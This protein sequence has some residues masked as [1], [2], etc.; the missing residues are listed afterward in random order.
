MCGIAGMLCRAGAPPAIAATPS[1][2]DGM[3]LTG[4]VSTQLL[5]RQLIRAPLDRPDAI[6]LA[7]VIDHVSPTPTARDPRDPHD[8]PS[9]LPAAQLPR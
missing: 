8:A 6:E 5:H 2:A 1:S 7:M 3:A 9:L 4:V